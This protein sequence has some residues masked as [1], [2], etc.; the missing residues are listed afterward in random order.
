MSLQGLVFVLLKSS[1]NSVF[2]GLERNRPAVVTSQ[3]LGEPASALLCSCFA[4]ESL[5]QT[6]PL[7]RATNLHI[8]ANRVPPC[9]FVQEPVPERPQPLAVKPSSAQGPSGPGFFLF[10]TGARPV[11]VKVGLERN[12]SVV[13]KTANSLVYPRRQQLTPLPCG[14]PARLDPSLEL[15]QGDP[16]CSFPPWPPGPRQGWAAAR[17]VSGRVNSA[18]LNISQHFTSHL[19]RLWI[20]SSTRCQHFPSS[21][22]PFPAV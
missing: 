21:L 17:T 18:F 3:L 19:F 22:G 14:G 11:L 10:S 5:A 8:K 20:P 1:L 9:G 2:L 16:P 6:A 15:N 13:G 7:S 12:R 4:S